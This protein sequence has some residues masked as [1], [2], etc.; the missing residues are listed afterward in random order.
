MKVLITIVVA[1]L[2]LFHS[3]LDSSVQTK[4]LVLSDDPVT[5]MELPNRIDAVVEE[6][7]KV[8]R[9]TKRVLSV[10]HSIFL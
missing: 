8:A 2:D 5:F 6:V 9:G 7:I 4:L 3:G 1:P 10:S